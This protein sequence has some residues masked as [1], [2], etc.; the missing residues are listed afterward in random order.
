MCSAP[1]P[2]QGSTAALQAVPSAPAQGTGL[3]QSL[4]PA[5]SGPNTATGTDQAPR[6]SHGA[7]G[8]SRAW[9]WGC[10][11]TNEGQCRSEGHRAGASPAGRLCPDCHQDMAAWQ[12]GAA[13]G[14]MAPTL[15]GLPPVPS[16]TC[17]PSPHL[18]PGIPCCPQHRRGPGPAAP[19]GAVPAQAQ[20]GLAGTGGT[21]P[22]AGGQPRD[23]AGG[24]PQ[25]RRRGVEEATQGNLNHKRHKKGSEQRHAQSTGTDPAW[26]V[27][28]AVGQR[29]R[30]LP[31]GVSGTELALRAAEHRAA[32]STAGGG[33]TLPPGILGTGQMYLYHAARSFPFQHGRS[34][35]AVAKVRP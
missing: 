22:G 5:P 30:Q 25:G 2:R 8:T 19:H 9:P 15:P 18:V 17:A 6:P 11:S 23:S 3:S 20:H 24:T 34:L 4:S 14:A 32:G 31:C 1:S 13:H 21:P 28:G 26:E 27:Q 33:S 12:L 35:T 16:S 10:G 7:R 29:C